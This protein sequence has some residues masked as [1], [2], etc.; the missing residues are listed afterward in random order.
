MSNYSVQKYIQKKFD[1]IYKETTAK[2]AYDLGLA[3][4]MYHAYTYIKTGLSKELADKCFSNLDKNNEYTTILRT[5]IELD[6]KESVTRAEK[7]LE[8]YEKLKKP[9]V[10][11]SD[12]D[13]DLLEEF[14][15]FLYKKEKIDVK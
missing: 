2:K 3:V 13:R 10:I 7:I 12:K 11:M 14:M 9:N 1:D 8:Q 4:G 15:E 5:L 6:N